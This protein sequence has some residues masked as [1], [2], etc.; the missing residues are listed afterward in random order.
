MSG[1]SLRFM[2]IHI[3][4]QKGATLPG[5][6]LIQHFQKFEFLSLIELLDDGMHCLV[7]ADYEDSNV[8]DNKFK[9]IQLLKKI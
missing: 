5:I 2:Q 1:L 7:K 9:S 4:P 8:L 6:E 3:T